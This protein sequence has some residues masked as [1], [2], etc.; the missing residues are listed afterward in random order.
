MPPL[1]L[2]MGDPAGIGPEI[3]VKAWRALKD[4]PQNAFAVI[5]PLSV[6]EDTAKRLGMGS[7]LAVTRL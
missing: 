6:M 7:P 4:G 3:T 5:A 2:S 1:V